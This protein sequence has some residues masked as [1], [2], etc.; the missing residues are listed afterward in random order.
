MLFLS[1]HWIARHSARGIGLSVHTY[2][3]RIIYNAHAV[4]Q[5]WLW[6]FLWVYLPGQKREFSNTNFEIGKPRWCFDSLHQALM[7]TEAFTM[8]WQAEADTHIIGVIYLHTLHSDPAHQERWL[9]TWTAEST[10]RCHVLTSYTS[11]CYVASVSI[12]ACLLKYS[13]WQS[14][15]EVQLK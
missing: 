12:A 5:K 15:T 14:F 9:Y 4:L 10:L 13:L 6:F 3:V 8:S 1:W 2:V 7:K 11:C